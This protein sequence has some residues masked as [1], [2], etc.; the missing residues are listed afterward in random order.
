MKSFP[1]GQKRNRISVAVFFAALALSPMRVALGQATGACPAGTGLHVFRGD[2]W[3]AS[4]IPTGT[5]ASATSAT[6]SVPGASGFVPTMT[7]TSSAPSAVGGFKGSYFFKGFTSVPT[8]V[9]YGVGNGLTAPFSS[10][11][12]TLSFS[13][14]VLN[15]RVKWADVDYTPQS[16]GEEVFGATAPGSGWSFSP[17]SG[18]QTTYLAST[19]DIRATNANV[20]CDDWNNASCDVQADNLGPLSSATLSYRVVNNSVG[21]NSYLR[22]VSFCLANPAQASIPTWSEFSKWFAAFSLMFVGAFAARKRLL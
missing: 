10:P 7:L 8:A 21:A 3:P 15:L 17:A 4:L 14:P 11:N 5:D 2:S 9:V 13:Q 16:G 12:T 20:G 22:E 19:S 6:V 18:A 1:F